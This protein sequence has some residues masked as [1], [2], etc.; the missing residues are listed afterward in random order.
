MRLVLSRSVGGVGCQLMF[1]WILRSLP[2]SLWW[3]PGDHAGKMVR[4]PSL[5]AGKGVS[6]LLF[7]QGILGYI[8]SLSD[9]VSIL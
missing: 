8:M 6:W 3:P 5:W 2:N 4:A 9:K 1:G 7:P